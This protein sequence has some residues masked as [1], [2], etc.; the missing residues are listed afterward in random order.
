MKKSISVLTL[1]VYLPI[2]LLLYGI[3]MVFLSNPLLAHT[4]D[5]EGTFV[6]H[7]KDDRF[8]PE[9][10][11]IPQGSTVIFENVDTQPHWPATNIH[12]T[13]RLYP[14]SDAEKCGTSEKK[15]NF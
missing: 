12:P 11:T 4:V 13:H 5:T 8:E 7:M 6:I 9:T 2:L 3:F 15:R 10:I 14:N 1:K